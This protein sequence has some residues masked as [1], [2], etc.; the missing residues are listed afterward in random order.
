VIP[1]LHRFLIVLCLLS[2]LVFCA[3]T[4]H[5]GGTVPVYQS[6]KTR[7][8]TRP[9][10]RKPSLNRYQRNS[11][12][13]LLSRS[14]T[15]ATSMRVIAIQVQFADSLMG[16]QPGSHRPELRDST[17]FAGE[18]AHM[19]DYFDGASRKKFTLEP[20][21]GGVLYTLSLGMGYYGR[22]IYEEERV[23]ELAAELIA[24]SDDGFDFSQYDHVFISHAGAGQ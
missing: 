10:P 16:G 20:T 4:A 3:F 23:V 21:V 18:A 19:S 11:L 5:A 2:A 6:G 15:P 17:F 13:R 1:S 22:D 7:N 9:L 14:A 24:L 8:T 12:E